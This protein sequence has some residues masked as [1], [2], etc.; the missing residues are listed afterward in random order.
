MNLRIS[1]D[2]MLLRM[3]DAA[4]ERGTCERLQVGAIVAREGR[5]LAAGYNGSPRGLE[6][7]GPLHCKLDRPC[8]YATHA[9][10]NAI[11]WAANAGVA[12]NGAELYITD[13]PCEGCAKAI[14]NAGISIVHFRRKYRL[15]AGLDLL[16]AAGV[17]WVHHD[18]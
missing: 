10:L 12:T 15:I 4:A 1:R 9:E 2:E 5:P 3:A 17:K 6:H 13:S 7:C 16:D 18:A 8:T 11:T 14:I